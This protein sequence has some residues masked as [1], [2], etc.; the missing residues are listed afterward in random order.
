MLVDDLKQLQ[1]RISFSYWSSGAGISNC[2]LPHMDFNFKP[3]I[4]LLW[5]YLVSENS[6]HQFCTPFSF[7]FFENRLWHSA[8]EILHS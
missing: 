8:L 6:Y 7:S 3:T 2:L 4:I 5:E 1:E